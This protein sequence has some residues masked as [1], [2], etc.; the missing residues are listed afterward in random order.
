MTPFHLRV[1]GR[2]DPFSPLENLTLYREEIQNRRVFLLP[3]SYIKE[4]ESYP[5]G[6][7]EDAI[8]NRP[9]RARLESRRAGV[10]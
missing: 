5:D 4:G 2:L 3:E 8:D 7:W 10:W 6:M 9:L 1:K